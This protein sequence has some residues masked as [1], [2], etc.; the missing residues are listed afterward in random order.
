MPRTSRAPTLRPALGWLVVLALPISGCADPGKEYVGEVLE[1][2]DRMAE[3]PLWPGFRAAETPLALYDG[4]D[5]YLIRHPRPPEGF[6]SLRGIDEARRLSGR[7]PQMVANTV[8]ELAGVPTATALVDRVD[9]K[10]AEVPDPPEEVAALL[11]HETFHTFQDAHHPEWTADEMALFTY[12]VD[13]LAHLHAR[14]LET[15]ALRRAVLAPDRRRRECW[16]R[17]ALTVR[18]R[19]FGA[20][21]ED[22]AAYERGTELR[23]GLAAYVQR[24]A[25]ERTGPPDLSPEGYPP[26][27]VRARSYQVGL[28]LAWLLD[29]LA[30]GWQDRL[31]SDA[32]SAS[33][34]L[35]GALAEVL[36]SSGG[37]ACTAT[38]DE[39]A[40]TR[41][42]ARTDLAALAERRQAARRAFEEAPGWRVWVIAPVEAPF[43]PAGF[44]PL[45][46]EMLSG[47]DVLHRRILRLERED[48]ELA[49]DRASLTR[50]A[51]D[52]PL[53]QGVREV[54]VTGL[55]TEPT[56]EVEGSA[57][58]IEGEGVTGRF[59]RAV[60][61]RE[62]RALRVRLQ[63]EASPEAGRTLER[64]RE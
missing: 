44:D 53:F 26:A 22:A 64:G 36:S 35:D 41:S 47:G 18:E 10:E 61:E 7:H 54:L 42:V 32:A 56:V 9:R 38:R 15:A 62:G 45:N 33:A 39:V 40:R 58:R 52:H 1:A 21:P 14:R 2:F 43:R 24:R 60:L 63:E 13:G 37:R 3:R 23:E 51:G 49:V 50:P 31:G 6:K 4:R 34:G 57:V 27:E 28:T 5:T 48:A 17:G 46:V 11:I 20:L 12:P 25:L 59:G 16:A 30:A 19:R 8:V 29:E 55:R